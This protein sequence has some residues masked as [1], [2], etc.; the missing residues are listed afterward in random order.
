[1]AMNL[2]ICAKEQKHTHTYLRLFC[3]TL[4]GNLG[5]IWNLPSWERAKPNQRYWLMSY[6]Y[7]TLCVITFPKCSQSCQRK[8]TSKFNFHTGPKNP[9]QMKTKGHVLDSWDTQAHKPYNFCAMHNHHLP[10]HEPIT[11]WQTFSPW[12]KKKKRERHTQQI[13]LVK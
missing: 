13:T 7:F 1:L 6:R 3:T 11:L 10:H 9:K 5:K 4:V 12:K 2:F 8:D